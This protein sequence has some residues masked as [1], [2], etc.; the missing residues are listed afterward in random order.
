[1]FDLDAYIQECK[2]SGYYEKGCFFYPI[3]KFDN[4]ICGLCAKV[5][6]PENPISPEGTI[7]ELGN[8][9]ALRIKIMGE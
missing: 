6:D 9:T 5:N 4:D 2:N 1:M 8:N 7:E 3:Y